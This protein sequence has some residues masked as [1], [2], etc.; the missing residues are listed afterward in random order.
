MDT[1]MRPTC[2][3]VA[4]RSAMADRRSFGLE[5]AHRQVTRGAVPPSGLVS[6]RSLGYTRGV[7][8]ERR[9]GTVQGLAAAA[10]FGLSAPLA[11]ALLDDASP[12]LLAGLLY[13]GAAIALSV[14]M[15]LRRSSSEAR[16]VRRDV[17]TLAVVTVTGGVLAPIAMLTGLDRTS[18]VAGALLLNLET[19]FTILLAVLVFSEFLDRPSKVAASAIIA[20]ATLLAFGPGAVR[21]D[22]IG[23]T[24]IAVAC[25]LWAVDN[26]LT[27]RLTTRDPFAIVRAKAAVAAT[28]NLA[29]AAARGTA[30]PTARTVVAAMTLGA[31]AYGL[32][33]LLD[34][35]ALRR[36]GAAREAA[37]FAT[38][39]FFG[40]LAAVPLL[41]ESVTATDL[42]AAAAMGLGVVL[43]ARSHHDHTHQHDP[44]THEHRHRHDDLHHDHPHDPPV[45]GWHTHPHH[46][47]PMAHAHPHDSDLH[48]RHR[49]IR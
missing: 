4:H 21:A 15:V 34:A 9:L 27:Q 35:Y 3:M 42:A 17:P 1:A 31:A 45:E 13:G 23:V 36:L 39:P 48:H 2:F 10:L 22:A 18:G 32:S 19:P 47:E 8:S 33:V 37:L 43:L 25:A 5:V 29:I 30:L 49:H 12:E 6:C 14:A 44:T 38:G 41:N 28:A 11:K 26:N 20:G 7:N 46:H 16:I 40:A 24:L